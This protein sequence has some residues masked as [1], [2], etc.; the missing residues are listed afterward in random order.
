MKNNELLTTITDDLIMSMKPCYDPAEIGMTADY[1]ASVIDFIKD[2]RCKVKNLQDIQ[3]VIKRSLSG[4]ESAIYALFCSN[5]VRHLMK[6]ERSITALDITEKYLNGNA[7]IEALREA[8]NAADAA[9]SAYA[10]YAAADA[11]ANTIKINKSINFL[12]LLQ[13]AKQY[14]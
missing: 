3:W 10:A 7:T 4:K 8:K 2:Y 9:A 6:D 11:A 14:E 12:T 5:Q 1:S 13:K